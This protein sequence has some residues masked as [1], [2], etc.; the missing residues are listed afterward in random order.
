[1]CAVCFDLD[2][3][4]TDPKLGI[5]NCIRYALERLGLGYP[6]PVLCLTE[7]VLAPG[8]EFGVFL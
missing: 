5:A 8:R 4:L 2:G 6:G 3:T 1:M 7:R